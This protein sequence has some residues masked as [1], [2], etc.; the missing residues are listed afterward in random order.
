MS[1]FYC[2]TLLMMVFSL[3][4]NGQNRFLPFSKDQ[5]EAEVS[6]ESLVPRKEMKDLGDG[7]IEVTYYF[8]GAEVIDK[9]SQDDRYNFLQIEGFGQ[10]GQVGAPAL[11]MRNDQ[12]VLSKGTTPQLRLVDATYVDYPDFMVHPALE[13]ARDTQGAPDPVFQKD[14]NIYN[15][16]AFF[17]EEQV[18]ISMNQVM[19]DIRISAVRI[20]PVQFNP[21]QRTLR[22]YSKLVYRFYKGEGNTE[23]TLGQRTLDVLK[24]E[25]MNPSQLTESAGS[26]TD[27]VDPEAKDYIIITHEDFNEA[28]NK[29][30]AW[31]GSLGYKVDVVSQDNWTSDEVRE[32]IAERYRTWN[33]KPKYYVIIG[34]VEFVPSMPFTAL[35][36]GEEFFSDLYYACMDGADDF[37]PDM[38]R[39]RLS[40]E[41]VEQANT[42]VDKIIKYEKNPVEDADFYQN[43]V[44]CAQFQDV[45]AGNPRDGFAARR[46]CHTSEDIRDYIT[47]Q[48]YNVD[49]IY[50]SDPRNNPTNFNNGY[51]SNGEAIAPE[52]LRAN[53]F[54]WDGDADDIAREI[55]EGKFYVFHRDHGYAGGSGW[56][57]P[58]FVTN[59]MDRLHNGDKLPVVFSINC[60]TGEFSLDECFAEK[61]L[62]LEDA[63]AVAVFAA[64]YYSLSGPNDGLSAGLVEA[65][66]PNPGMLPSFGAGSRAVNAPAQGF[67]EATTTLGDVLNLG[68]LRMNQTWAPNDRY[69][70]YTYRLFHLFGDPAMKMW[71]QQPT[72]IEAQMPADISTGDNTIQ[73]NG[74]SE[75]GALVTITVDGVLVAK[76]TIVGGRATL[77]F[78]PIESKKEAVVTI[79]NTNCRPTYKTYSLERVAPKACFSIKETNPIKGSS[80]TVHFISECTGKL[81]GYIWDF[82]STNIEMLEG[83]TNTSENP[84]VR[85]ITPGNYSVSLVA[86]ND[87]GSH[88]C[89]IENAVEFVEGLP[90]ASCQ[91]NTIYLDDTYDFGI[92]NVEIGD[93]SISSSGSFGDNG[94]LDQT[95][96][97]VFKVSDATVDVSI[98]FGTKMYQNV[99]V[100]IDKNNDGNLSDDELV[101]VSNDVIGTRVLSFN[102]D[103]TYEKEA[104][105]RMRVVTD[106][107]RYDITTACQ[108]LHYGQ[109]ED[110]S[111]IFTSSKPSIK[112]SIKFSSVPTVKDNE[113]V[114]YLE[115]SDVNTTAILEQGVVLSEVS[116]PTISDVKYTVENP[117]SLTSSIN[118]TGLKYSTTYYAKAYI[119]DKSDVVYSDEFVFITGEKSL[120][121]AISCTNKTTNQVGDYGFGIYQVKIGDKQINSEGSFVDKGYVDQTDK[122]IFEINSSSVDC[123]VTV[124]T[125]YSENIAIFIDKNND[126]ILSEH[127]LVVAFDNTKGENTL[128]FTVDDSYLLNTILRMRVMS[129]YSRDKITSPCQDLGYGQAEDFAVRFTSV[130][131]TVKTLSD[132][133]VYN[134]YVEVGIEVSG[135]KVSN[136]IEQGVVVSND[137]APTVDDLKYEASKPYDL[138][139]KVSLRDLE[140]NTSYHARAFVING[141]GVTYG[142]DITFK[143]K[144]KI[145]TAIASCTNSLNYTTN[146]YDF[147]I[148]NVQFDGK[149]ITSE[150]SYEEGGYI[151]HSLKA[152]WDVNRS[153]VELNITVGSSYSENVA[154]YIDKDN[155][156]E[157]TAEELVTK[158]DNITGMNLLSF[159]VSDD[160]VRNHPLRMRIISEYSRYEITSPCQELNYGQAEDF[161]VMF[162]SNIVEVKI[163]TA[164][165]VYQDH[166]E[167]DMHVNGITSNQIIEQGVVI[168]D[169]PLPT[170]VNSTYNAPK[171]YMSN[172]KVIL[173][174][175]KYQ[176]L[177]YARAFVKTPY[178]VT[179]GEQITF[180]TKKQQKLAP[181]SHAIDFQATS[182][183]ESVISLNWEK[184]QYETPD[185]FMIQWA[186]SSEALTQP[187]NGVQYSDNVRYVSDM[188][189][190]IEIEGLDA[191][192]MYSFRIFAFNNRGEEVAYYTGGT[193]PEV[194]ARTQ[195]AA[196]YN[197][198]KGRGIQ[199]VKRVIFNTIDNGD[200]RAEGYNDFT[201]MSTAIQKNNTYALQVRVNNPYGETFWTYA[202]FDWNNNGVFEDSE[203]Y[204]I[205]SVSS[206]DKL[207]SHNIK[208]PSGAHSG[209]CRLRIVYAWDTNEV[210]PSGERFN[211][212]QADDYTMTVGA[213]NDN[214]DIDVDIMDAN[215]TS[216]NNVRIFPN[217]VVSKMHIVLPSMPKKPI[218]VNIID[219]SGQV[220]AHAYLDRMDN[221]VS[222][223]ISSGIYFVRIPLQ[224]KMILKKIVVK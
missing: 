215:L 71:T 131:P 47:G 43:G 30:A 36:A 167:V 97:G 164:P 201:S 218:K 190:T 94:Y 177:F 96:K 87:Y 79:S 28:A 78:D 123:D 153:N 33:P 112:P 35:N 125:G 100:F 41:N 61:F 67:A 82:G 84:V 103:D 171:P 204:H 81:S 15:K 169:F 11:P 158:A 99:G 52:L 168:S 90:K 127:E 21:V 72:V 208:V 8:Q 145:Q 34:D 75:E 128:T 98:T 9:E 10:L 4:V 65:I 152:I 149:Q 83:T 129:D 69:L 114:V 63:G 192:T 37:T 46:F 2:L 159:D 134:D 53:G 180:T 216:S 176:T 95:D 188:Q 163:L 38:A 142:N 138:N 116:N 80:A 42:V 170:L 92:Y 5:R 161:S 154:I 211:Y 172:S 3:Y 165:K 181:V 102:V 108:E 48:G 160:F 196:A 117:A 210:N 40:V 70:L 109:A 54:Q 191:G 76:S 51:Y 200:V 221:I 62:R 45:Q 44:N 19:R 88:R 111:I 220:V 85:Y 156:G 187:V 89:V 193:I 64:S 86:S 12:F 6:K 60:H 119:K 130:S 25:V 32:A 213:M 50:Y 202:W 122:G 66:W 26:L 73:V 184:D 175:L 147:G 173:N 13:P 20:C 126:G 18:K 198:I 197:E 146:D 206:E 14:E 57:H 59:Q 179:Y 178:G 143:T 150:G 17:P 29:L 68:L 189:R 27:E 183:G 31:K 223:N 162:T 214:Q 185:G 124:G 205:G 121:P 144:A 1:K 203:K 91:N 194:T 74:V 23:S 199:A 217:P 115:A 195:I 105:V 166:V 22:V 55:N 137:E 104:K 155:N 135:V 120:L 39:G 133:I 151:D 101:A 157:L 16:D 186:R 148:Y 182:V 106:Y 7:S 110:Y 224:D 219:V 93:L 56:A 174:G 140:S 77:N 209:S 132:P 141:S 212:F 58:G 24:S 118:I 107:S 222:I 113:V 139:C 136:I 49:R 207:L